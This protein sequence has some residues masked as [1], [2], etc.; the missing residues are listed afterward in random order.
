MNFFFVV[1]LVLLVFVSSKDIKVIH[2]SQEISTKYENLYLRKLGYFE[3]D[4]NLIGAAGLYYNQRMNNS[5]DTL[6][7]LKQYRY[8]IPKYFFN[9]KISS[10]LDKKENNKF[11]IERKQK[12][13]I[14]NVLYNFGTWGSFWSG[15]SMKIRFNGN[16]F[17]IKVEND[18]YKSIK[19]SKE[20]FDKII[21]IILEG[22]KQEQSCNYEECI[23]CNSNCFNE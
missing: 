7:L 22:F 3:P 13:E 10:L 11:I 9:S 19:V 16:G 21:S 17:S 5:D 1:L 14:M 4:G 2:T 12:D 23:Q 6:L 18:E 15:N 8:M 20:S